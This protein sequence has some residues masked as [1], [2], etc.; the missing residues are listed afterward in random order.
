MNVV[1]MIGMRNRDVPT[2]RPVPVS[3]ISML[4]VFGG[5]CHVQTPMDSSPMIL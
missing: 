2:P 1:D 5:D 4:A 3:V